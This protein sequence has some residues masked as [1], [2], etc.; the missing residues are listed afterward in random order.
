MPTIKSNEAMKFD[1][2]DV[3]RRYFGYLANG[4]PPKLLEKMNASTLIKRHGAHG[5]GVISAQKQNCNDTY[6]ETKTKALV[7]DIQKAGYRYI[8]IYGCNVDANE[9]K[10]NF[11]PSFIVFPFSTKTNQ[12]MEFDPFRQFVLDMCR[13]YIQDSVLLSNPDNTTA[14][15][16][17]DGKAIKSVSLDSIFNEPSQIYLNPD[18]TTF[19]ERFRRT[20]SG[21]ILC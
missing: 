3:M 1:K 21:E 12:F 15:Y 10:D 11:V 17:K 18:P 6:N 19:G 16:D 14:Y 7:T 5:F 8:P 13:K 20:Y 2:N 9:T 4:H